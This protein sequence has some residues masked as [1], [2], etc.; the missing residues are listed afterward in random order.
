MST[1]PST[2]GQP[3]GNA[4]GG[5]GRGRGSGGGGGGYHGGGGG[6]GGGGYAPAAAGGYVGGFGTNA[7]G[8]PVA[9]P[10]GLGQG[11]GQGQ[12]RGRGLGGNVGAG[13]GAGGQRWSPD[14]GDADAPF[15]SIGAYKATDD[16]PLPPVD[17]S[18]PSS[19]SSSRS[20]SP[21]SPPH[22]TGRW[23]GGIAPKAA[24]H[25]AP[26][27]G[28]SVGENVGGAEPALP[29]FDADM[30]V[31]AFAEVERSR[32]VSGGGVGGDCCGCDGLNRDDLR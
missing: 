13:A 4:Q 27:V 30:F 22:P 6:G 19:A 2:A 11:L 8:G 18:H 28:K 32:Q 5:G 10:H 15:A 20:T 3:G 12:G 16:M 25:G 31:E 26:G 9:A 29:L 17:R 7:H 1:P 21:L 23:R 14:D 24:V